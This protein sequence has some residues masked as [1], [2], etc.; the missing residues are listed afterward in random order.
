MTG[1]RQ[2]RVIEHNPPRDFKSRFM[3]W[4]FLLLALFFGVVI[5]NANMSPNFLVAHHL[6]TNI[7]TFLVRGLVALTMTYCLLMGE[8]DLSV[9]S[10][11]VFAATTLGIVFNATGSVF[12]GMVTALVVGGLCGAFNGLILI[13]FK[14]LHSM[15]VTLGTMILFRGLAERILGAEATG[16][17]RSVTWFANLFDARI[18]PVPYFFIFFCALAAAFA[19]VMHRTTFGR[20]MFAIGAN[21]TAAEY[22]GIN[23]S[24]TRLKVFALSGLIC[25]VSAIMFASWTGSI[26]SNVGEGYEIEAIAMCVLGGMSTAGGKGSL[27]GVLIAIFTVGLLQ[28]GMSLMNVNPQ[29]VRIIIGALLIIV[30]TMQNI[31]RII[32][33]KITQVK[34]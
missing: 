5:M 4:E 3:R 2:K 30:V 17:M 9:G 26:R 29:T 18:G 16:G 21:R 32:G 11:V 7:N 1:Q 25:G 19:F 13:K 10:I 33:K 24:K 23:V 12:L 6:F 20:H 27:P 34:A 15:I 31:R 8:I 14:E 22:A 28:F